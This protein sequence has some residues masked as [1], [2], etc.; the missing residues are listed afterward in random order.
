MKKVGSLCQTLSAS[1]RLREALVQIGKTEHF[2]SRS[3]L[4]HIGDECAGVYLVCSGEVCLEVPGVPQ[5][6]RTFSAGSVLGL[7][8]TFSE[9][10]YSLTAVSATECDVVHVG[11]KTFLKLMK[12]E[13][14]L[15]RQAMDILSRE[16]TFIMS[17]LRKS[18]ETVS[19]AA[20]TSA[21]S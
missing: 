19:E 10:P 15:C 3:V 20:L 9:K 16:V 21:A 11:E 18:A 17:A 13:P 8:S 7:P 2:L 6:T 1:A 4:F 14:D 5:L 12:A